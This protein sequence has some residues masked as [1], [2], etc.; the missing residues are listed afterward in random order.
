MSRS[1][2]G[3]DLHSSRCEPVC[4]PRGIPRTS[5]IQAGQ[6]KWLCVCCVQGDCQIDAAALLATASVGA[7][8]LESLKEEHEVNGS[9]PQRKMCWRGWQQ[10]ASNRLLG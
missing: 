1:D 6:S 8:A 3:C 5:L 2:G 4:G 10:T 7:E 9:L